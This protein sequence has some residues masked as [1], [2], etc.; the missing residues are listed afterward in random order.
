MTV[1]LTPVVLG[2]KLGDLARIDSLA[3]GTRV[4]ISPPDRLNNGSAVTA[5]KK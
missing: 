5:A 4:V 2:P 1:A 3:P